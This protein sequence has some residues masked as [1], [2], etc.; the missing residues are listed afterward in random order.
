MTKETPL[1]AVGLRQDHG[2]LEDVVPVDSRLLR[3]AYMVLGTLSVGV[4]IV[5]I[6][7]PGLPIR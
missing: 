6:F 5:G 1:D 3:L 7:V 4:G 2:D